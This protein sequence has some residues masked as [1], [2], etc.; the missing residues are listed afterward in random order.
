MANVKITDL[1]AAQPLTGAESVPVV[2]DGITVRTTTGAISAAPSQT[3]TFITVNQ[4]PTLPNSRAL[5]SVSGIGITDNGAQST[6]SLS[7]QG[8]AASLNA[9]GEGFAVKTDANTI[10]PREIAVSGSGIVI[11][12]GDGQ[13]GDPTISLDGLVLSLANVSGA[14]IAA[15]PNNGTITPRILT[16]T[17]GDISVTNGD[18]ASGDPVFD[19]VNT[20][21]T[22]GTYGSTTQIPVITVDAKGRITSASLTPST[23]GGTVTYVSALT[24]G[25]S[26]TDLSSTVVDPTTTPVITLNVPTA[27][28]TN[29]GVLSPTDW[30]TFNN[31]GDGTVTAVSVVSANGFAGSSSGGAAPALTLSTSVSGILKGNGTAIS[32]ATS[33]TDYAPATSGTSI[34]YGNGSGGFSNVTIGS[35]VSFAGGTLS[36]TGSGGTVTSI[37][38]GTGL[39]GGTITS[40][41]T[42]A[43]D[44]TVATLT[45]IQTLTNKT[46]SGASNTLSNIGN[47]SLTNSSVTINGSSVSLGGS[48]TVTATASNPLT[49][50]TGLSGTSYNGS[51]AVTIAIDSTVATLTGS[52]TLTNKTLTSPVI[53]TI[54]NTGTLTLPTSTDTLVGRATTDTLTNKSISGSSN[55][56]TNIPNSALTNSSVT[57]GTTSI[58]LGSSS[59]T[60]GG[61]TTVTVTQDPTSALELATKQYVDGLASTGLY[62][63]SPVQAATTQSLAAQTGGTVTYNNGSSGVGATI[64]LSVALTTLDGYSLSN[65]NRILVKDETNQAYNGVYTWA[66]GGT[67]LTRSTDTDSYGPGTGDLSENDYFFVQNGT[68]NKGNSYVCTTSG[69]I[70]FG[71]TAI[72]FAQF[73]TSQVYTGTSPINVSGTVISLNTVPVTSGGTGLTSGTSG[74]IPYFSGSTT[75]ASSAALTANALV[76][77]GGAG[78][79]PS[80]TTTGTGVLTALGTNVGSAGAFVVNGGALGTPSSGTLTNATGLPV[81]T[82]ISGFGTGVATALAVNT[83]TAGS[84]VVNGGALGTP[85]SGTLTNATGLPLST[86]VTGTLPVANGGT[87]LNTAPTNGQIDI[88]S[89]GVGFVRT[90]LTAGSGVTITNGAGSITIAS[91]GGTVTSVAQTFTGGLISVSGSPVTTSGTLA[92]TVA[93]TSGGIPYFSSAS[94]WASS[95][96]LAANALMIGGGAGVAPSTT[97]TGTGVLTA[98]GTSVGSAGAFVVNGGALGTPSSG[99]LTNATG[100]PLSTGVTGTLPVANGGTGQTSYTDGQLLI[101]NTLTTSL[102]KATLTAGSGITITNGNGSITIASTGGSGTVTS[103]AQTFTGGLISVSGSPITSSGTLALT[104][105]GTSGGI[106]YFSSAS[107]WASSAALTANALVIGGG[108]GV[109]PSTTTTGTGVL[110]AL[111]VNTGTAGAFVVNGGALGTPSSGTVTNLTGTASINI[112][113]TV[114]ATT[115]NTGAFTTISASG[116]ITSTVATGTAPFTVASTTQVANL[117]AATAGTATNATNTAITSNST[118]ATNYL[119]FVNATTGNLGQLVN[120]SITCNPSTGAI[121]GGISGGTF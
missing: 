38:A 46:I 115:A 62:Y 114:G 70:T 10:T 35:G 97:T 72:T 5:S 79:S 32:A 75:I 118:N 99:T 41:G 85:S 8:A 18:G 56:L 104:V 120:S 40:S 25:T 33:G 22:P 58:S 100:L 89:T 13:A 117:N 6:I 17:A 52:Q 105:A 113:G 9:A 36:A 59:L 95:A 3:Q 23:S 14:G 63:H 64:T 21:V 94:T 109:A 20:A 112:N 16:G 67:V 48:V 88:G 82:G 50:G 91:T 69:T 73:S 43:I 47:S 19:L 78:V 34:L 107:T 60:L 93:G 111:G 57:V 12:D 61:L 121:T 86:G 68:V 98:L 45:G 29:R 28:A 80:T 108:A 39:T 1:P 101:G 103:V 4:E 66:T 77:G 15:F 42:I 37:T 74:G 51:A 31:K 83:G 2:Q 102:T 11:N 49:I 110:T 106:P 65:T 53:S 7:L 24:L 71:T 81:S 27:S 30:T 44:S 116:V 26:G 76:I 55:T 90:T 119:T 54:V 96:A 92:L 84:F 87:G